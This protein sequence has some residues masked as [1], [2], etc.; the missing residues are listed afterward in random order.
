MIKT[1]FKGGFDDNLTYLIHANDGCCAIVDPCGECALELE[2][3]NIPQENMKYILITH[4]HSDHFDALDKVKKLFPSAQTAGFRNAEFNKDIPLNDLSRLEFGNSFI[5]VI[6]TP[7]H[8]RGSLCYIYNQ[9]NAIFT[10]DT[11]F[12]DCIGFCRSP[13][14]MAQSLRRLRE[15]PDDLTIYSGH[16]YGSVPF[17]TLAEEKLKNP[18]FSIEFIENLS[19]ARS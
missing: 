18:E 16:D 13:K 12:I 10:G 19:T 3:L 9:D 8:S 6:H 14:N 7:G 5:E 1:L 4:E 11:L 15:L 2:R 17:R